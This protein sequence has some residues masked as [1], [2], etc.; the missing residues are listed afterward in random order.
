MHP[1]ARNR[2]ALCIVAMGNFKRPR[3]SALIDAD[4]ALATIQAKGDLYGIAPESHGEKV[5]SDIVIPAAKVRVFGA[6]MEDPETLKPLTS[7]EE[8]TIKD[9]HVI[10]IAMHIDRKVPKT[11]FHVIEENG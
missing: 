1:E 2:E 9:S 10:D 4:T 7:E 6:G 3:P 11:D 5:V 8:K